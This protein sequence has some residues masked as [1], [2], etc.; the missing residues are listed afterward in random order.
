M[1]I[2]FHVI[3]IL[4]FTFGLFI[5]PGVILLNII[6]KDQTMDTFE[7][8]IL[9]LG[10]SI[11]LIPIIIFSL[12]FLLSTNVSSYITLSIIIILVAY[13]LFRNK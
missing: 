3:A 4:I 11:S 13:L 6:F 2:L 7:K 10:I 12:N 9:S 5:L 1:Q 8:C